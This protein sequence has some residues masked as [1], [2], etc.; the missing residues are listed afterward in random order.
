[1]IPVLDSTTDCLPLGR[2]AC[3]LAELK[4]A[5]V[6]DSR[7]AQSTTRAEIFEDLLTT[8]A[9]FDA[10]SPDMVEAVWVGGS[11]VTGKIDPDDID[12]TFLLSGTAFRSLSSNNQ[13]REIWKFN[14]K[15]WLREK[16]G[17]RVESFLLIR[18]PI[19][20]PFTAGEVHPDAMNYVGLRGAW[21]DWWMR[22]RSNADKNS[23]PVIEDADP[24]RGYL[25]VNW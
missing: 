21:D 10:K 22:V 11:F 17:L 8:R 19:A 18:E 24:R 25:E 16:T 4:A 1:M 14:R 9:L 2:Y 5:F 23:S 12:C 20:N 3:S 6:D 7:F 13:R 15:G